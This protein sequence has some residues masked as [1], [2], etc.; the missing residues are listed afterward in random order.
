MSESGLISTFSLCNNIYF[1]M[2]WKH[3][4]NVKMFATQY[5]S[6]SPAIKT[7]KWKKNTQKSRPFYVNKRCT[8]KSQT[9]FLL[10]KTTTNQSA[11]TNERNCW[12]HT[13]AKPNSYEINKIQNELLIIYGDEFKMLVVWFKEFFLNFLWVVFAS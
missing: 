13:Y 7:N 6:F 11:Y 4:I 2:R 8:L 1:V 5:F 9:H 10:I 12:L 3:K